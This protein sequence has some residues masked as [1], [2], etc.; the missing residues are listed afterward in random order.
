[1][2]GSSIRNMKLPRMSGSARKMSRKG[3]NSAT[4]TT[5]V[6]LKRTFPPT[7]PPENRFIEK[8]DVALAW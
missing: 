5:S 3:G 2:G 7:R 6:T 4:K 8:M 1:M